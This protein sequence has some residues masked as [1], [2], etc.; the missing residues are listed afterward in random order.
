MSPP[1]PEFSP[2]VSVVSKNSTPSVRESAEL[3]GSP[4]C[5]SL[6]AFDACS[7]DSSSKTKSMLVNAVPVSGS[8]SLNPLTPVVK[9]MDLHFLD[10]APT[11]SSY[12]YRKNYMPGNQ[13]SVRSSSPQLL[14]AISLLESEDL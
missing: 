5:N 12:D 1:V 7:I 13:I 6:F 14:L 8:Q 4:L 3:A 9:P 11:C 2:D 10:F